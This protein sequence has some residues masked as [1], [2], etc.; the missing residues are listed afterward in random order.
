MINLHILAMHTQTPIFIQDARAMEFIVSTLNVLVLFI[1]A[2]A[3][4]WIWLIWV[5]LSL[6]TGY[7]SYNHNLHAQLTVSIVVGV[8]S[9][10]SLFSWNIDEE[11]NRECVEWGDPIL[12]WFG[13]LI[14]AG[15]LYHVFHDS[16]RVPIFEAMG[17]SSMIFG[18]YALSRVHVSSWIIF[19]YSYLMFLIASIISKDLS[20]IIACVVQLVFSGYGLTRY[21][22]YYEEIKSKKK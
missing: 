15:V 20:G 7:C 9:I 21:M 17:C 2:H 1:A 8:F 13:A 5:I 18:V 10:C 16:F 11:K 14:I 22:E 3:H 4:K 6:L 12:E 19:M